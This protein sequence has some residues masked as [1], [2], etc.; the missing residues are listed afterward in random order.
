MTY[1]FKTIN[2]LSQKKDL[3]ILWAELQRYCSAILRTDII[4]DW[5]HECT[6]KRM[7]F[8]DCIVELEYSNWIVQ[9]IMI[10]KK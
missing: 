5:I 10:E 3:T 9:S 8:D 6:I 1:N 7:I 4:I 2:K